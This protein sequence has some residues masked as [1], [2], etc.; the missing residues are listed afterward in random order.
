MALSLVLDFR[1]CQRLEAPFDAR[2]RLLFLARIGWC[3]DAL[4]RVQV[5]QADWLSELGGGGGDWCRGRVGSEDGQKCG[6]P[7]GCHSLL[8]QREDAARV[9]RGVECGVWGLREER[10]RE[11]E[12]ERV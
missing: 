7:S 2:R 4:P 6:G 3:G 9:Q 5:G 12:R 1:E 11:R 8:L 10:E